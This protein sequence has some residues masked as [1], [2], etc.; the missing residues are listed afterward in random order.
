ATIQLQFLIRLL[1]DGLMSDYLRGRCQVGQ[2]LRIE[3]P[4]GSFYLR[5]VERPLVFVA[6]GTGLSAFLGM[7]D[8]LVEQPNS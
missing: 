4:L 8:I 1:P 7:L 3:A 5:E 6:G 2:I